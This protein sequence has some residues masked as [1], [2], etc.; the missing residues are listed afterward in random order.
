MNSTS[1]DSNRAADGTARDWLVPLGGA[2]GLIVG[3]GPISVFAFGVFIGPLEAEF[4]WSRASL[5]I[6][7]ALCAFMSAI[8]L[9]FIGLLMDKFGVRRPMAG[10]ICLCA[11]KVA[12]SG[13][14]A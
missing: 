11:R 6:A 4:G 7:I 12:A 13:Q 9:P 10:A 2:L 5:G 14:S 8:T 1:T 3:N